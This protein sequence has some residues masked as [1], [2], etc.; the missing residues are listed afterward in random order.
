MAHIPVSALQSFGTGCFATR[1][2][3]RP[4]FDARTVCMSTDG[5]C[6]LIAAKVL[7]PLFPGA[8]RPAQPPWRSAV[9]GSQ[10]ILAG[11]I[12]G[13]TLVGVLWLCLASDSYTHGPISIYSH[14]NGRVHLQS[15]SNSRVS[16]PTFL[17]FPH[18]AIWRG[19]YEAASQ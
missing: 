14:L 3:S 11:N 7:F 2:P 6:R 4:G 13:L 12:D 18:S 19:M 10:V 5:C 16:C 9:R 15:Y 1:G 17:E 8:S